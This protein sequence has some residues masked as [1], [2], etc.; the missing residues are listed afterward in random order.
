M[1]P[2]KFLWG[3]SIS[4]FQFEMGD[5][6]GKYVDS[7][8]DWF[9]WVHDQVNIRN[10][11]VSGDFPENGINYWELYR[12]DHKL[13]RGLGLNA[14][15]LN[16]EWSRIFP[17]P[18]YEVSVG[19]ER[20][21]SSCISKIDITQS[22]LEKL[23]NNADLEALQHYE[24]IIKNI[25]ENEMKVFVCLNHFTLPVW[26]HDPISA[27]NTKLKKGPLGWVDERTVVE[28]TK[29]AAF[30]A[31]KLGELVDF[32][33]TFNEP[34]VVAEMGYT[35]RA[36]GFPPGVE[37]FN[38]MR[39]AAI[40]LAIAHA[41]SYDVIKKFD[42]LKADNDSPSIAAVGIIHNMIPF[43]PMNENSKV[44]I[45]A[46]NFMD[47][48]HNRFILEAI[49]SGWLNERFQER[50][51][52]EEK[53]QHLANRLDWIGVN[54]YS[55]AVVRGKFSILAKI[56]AG[57]NYLPELVKGYGMNCA[58]NSLSSD[59]RETSDFGWE[60]YPEGLREVVEKVLKYKL[61][62]YVTEN[63]IAD[64][65]DKLRS[66]YI[67]EHLRVVENMISERKNNIH[68]YFHWSLIDNYEWAR[69]FSMKFGL[70]E[71]NLETKERKMRKSALTFK[72]IIEGGTTYF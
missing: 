34:M 7:N 58:P 25:K 27:R 36:S 46:A 66:K 61:P 23:E 35:L 71:A 39:K 48:I 44:D 9:A 38:A 14:F 12:K 19:I 20:D 43:K 29:Y 63:G 45:G 72:K 56:F 55:R 28:F 59:K 3:V 52:K 60:L 47:L 11:I 69:G 31:W 1:I 65:K 8:S 24:E 30:L 53:K 37:D 2:E 41:R 18:T 17:K 67:L 15:R 68:G 49:T 32:W 6:E 54:Y 64:A 21:S 22:D 10:K 5:K 62:V 42:T 13:A 51:D 33:A 70:Y 50:Q 16:I 57:V 40:N 4:G 26:I